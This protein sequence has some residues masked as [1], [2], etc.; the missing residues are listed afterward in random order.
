M[1]NNSWVRKVAETI[2][3]LSESFGFLGNGGVDAGLMAD[4]IW[5]WTFN[6]VIHQEE[7]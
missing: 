7:Q 6:K 1:V 5:Q 3:C 2:T 4:V